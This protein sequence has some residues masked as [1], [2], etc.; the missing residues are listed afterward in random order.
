MSA[1]YKYINAVQ[2]TRTKQGKYIDGLQIWGLAKKDDD[3]LVVDGP[4]AMKGINET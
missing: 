4:Y 2:L 3:F 1:H